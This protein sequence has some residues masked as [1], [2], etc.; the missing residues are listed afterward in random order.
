MSNKQL[1]NFCSFLI[2]RHCTDIFLIITF[3]IDTVSN[4]HVKVL[5]K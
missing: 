2:E 1:F 4:K 3:V 5:D